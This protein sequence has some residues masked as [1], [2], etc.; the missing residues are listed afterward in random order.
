MYT[1]Y[2]HLC[3]ASK[4][5]KVISCAIAQVTAIMIH[6]VF[7]GTVSLKNLGRCKTLLMERLDNFSNLYH[8]GIIEANLPD[9]RYNTRV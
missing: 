3:Y 8:T 7:N 2:L 9:D 5:L 6:W 1:A 4:L